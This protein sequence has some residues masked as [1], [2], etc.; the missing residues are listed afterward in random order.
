V[1]CD[2]RGNDEGDA[3]ASTQEAK[4][5]CAP[6]GGATLECRDGRFV[7]TNVCRTCMTQ[8]DLIICTP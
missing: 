5:L 1:R 7:R 3:C 4:G 6:D 2:L 8:G